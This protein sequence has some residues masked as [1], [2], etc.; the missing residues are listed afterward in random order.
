MLLSAVLGAVLLVTLV[1]PGPGDRRFRGG[2]SGRR[3]YPWA[4]FGAPF[5][6]A[7]GSPLVAA[8]VVPLLAQSPPWTWAGAVPAAGTAFLLVRRISPPWWKRR[9][10]WLAGRAV[11]LL[12]L[13]AGVELSAVDRASPVQPQA[14]RI[15]LAALIVT[16]GYLACWRVIDTGYWPVLSVRD[17]AVLLAIA[18][19]AALLRRDE[20]PLLIGAVAAA[21]AAALLSGL[22]R[23][24]RWLRYGPPA[25]PRPP[26]LATWPPEPGQVWNATVDREDRAVVV[27]ELKPDCAYVLPVTPSETPVSRLRLP[28]AEWHRVLSD[29]AWLSLQLTPVPYTG[30]RSVRG[31]CPER[32]WERVGRRTLGA[33]R[34]RRTAL[35][36][37]LRAAANR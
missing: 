21:G 20:E 3:A 18:A 10:G 26:G 15:L 4:G 5:A 28:L 19:G 9:H 32:F 29:D 24:P 27:W 7:A 14:A 34:P 23:L 16:A 22:W 36:R 31:Q 1:T 35:R 17:G 25:W 33:P 8:P 13:V 6:V 12:F 30:F 11:L 2:R 37:R